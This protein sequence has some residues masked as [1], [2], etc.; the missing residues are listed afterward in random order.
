M[1]KPKKDAR[2]G[3]KDQTYFF[4]L[5]VADNEPNS[6]MAKENLKSICEEY[7]KDRY[8]MQEVDALTD[9]NSALKDSVFVT[10]TLVL[11]APGPRATIIGNLAHKDAV[12][13]ALRL[14]K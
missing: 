9:F 6:Q 5:Y 8:E 13:S 2:G 7:L 1:N 3:Q 12:I 4:K 10:P 11:I 14:R